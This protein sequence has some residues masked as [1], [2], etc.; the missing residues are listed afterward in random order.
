MYDAITPEQWVIGLVVSLGV[1]GGLVW[2]LWRAF[3]A[4][5]DDTRDMSTSPKQPPAPAGM[6]PVSIPVSQYGM[7]PG[8]MEQPPSAAPDIDAANAGMPRLSRNITDNEMIILLAAQRGADGKPRYSANAIHALVGGD[9]NAVLAR[10]KELRAVPPA[11]FRQP[12][13]TIAP[14]SHPVTGS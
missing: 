9:R 3:P 4:R 6:P 11:V 2:L 10:V 14:A 5:A 12:D 1:F 7:E 8:S 13:G